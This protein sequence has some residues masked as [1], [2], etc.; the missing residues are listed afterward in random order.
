MDNES[1]TTQHQHQCLRFLLTPDEAATALGMGRTYIYALPRSRQLR[2]VK[3]GTARRI[4][5]QALESHIA[6]LYVV[7]EEVA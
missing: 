6:R 5:V 3:L 4:P 1:D 2:S 7:Q